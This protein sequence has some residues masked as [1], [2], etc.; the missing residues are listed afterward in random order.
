VL[1][2]FPQ[3]TTVLQRTP[4]ELKAA[5]DT[6]FRVRAVE[7]PPDDHGARTIWHRGA[8]GAD[9]ITYVAS[10][11]TVTRQELFLFDDYY[12]WDRA[13]GL[14]TGV[15]IENAGSAGARASGDIAF[16]HDAVLGGRRLEHAAQ[17]LLPY[18]GTDK[19]IAHAKKALSVAA[20]GGSFD[21]D[22]VVTRSAGTVR[23]SD[24]KEASQELQKRELDA[25]LAGQRRNLWLFIGA[26]VIVAAV[27]AFWLATR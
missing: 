6:L 23:L 14:K 27:L 5:I 9:L 10:D 13:G 8:K 17:A 19:L 22:E 15:S 1:Q 3:V 26:A 7:S 18:A 21:G 24:L 16:D 20:R 11:G 25:R 2:T 4:A 12:L